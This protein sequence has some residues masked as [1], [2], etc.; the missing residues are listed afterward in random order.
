VVFQ[1]LEEIAGWLWRGERC[2]RIVRYKEHLGVKDE[3]VD[4]ILSGDL[5]F[6]LEAVF[7]Q[8]KGLHT[9]H[10]VGS[11]PLIHFC[12]ERVNSIVKN[13]QALFISTIS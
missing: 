6:W 1:H 11:T 2:N 10:E 4:K 7:A 12:D 13:A 8:L 5:N 9:Q 3:H